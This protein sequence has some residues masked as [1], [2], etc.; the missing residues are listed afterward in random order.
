MS[1]A[2]RFPGGN[3]VKGP[4]QGAVAV[5]EEP[6]TEV[7]A[8]A[9]TSIF[10]AR[11][12]IFDAKEAVVAYE[13]LY[14][15][16]LNNSFD[17]TDGTSATLNVIRNAFLVLG[18]L[19]I[20]GKRA[21]INF[22]K[23]LLERKTGLSL[24]PA[25]TVI[26]ILEDVD[27]DSGIVEACRELKEAGYAL[28][29]DD[30]VLSAG[31]RGGLL[32]LAD[33]IKA[34]FRQM[35]PTERKNVVRMYGSSCQFLAEKV[36]TREEFDEAQAA[37]YIYFQG[38]FFGKPVI[39]SAN[40]IPG[41]KINYVRMLAEI[42]RKELDFPS[43][44]HI[45][46]QDP[47]LSYTLLNYMNSA[48][49]AFRVSVS[50]IRQALTLLG[51]KEITKWAS[52]VIMTFI[53]ADKPSEVSLCSLIRARF[54]EALAPVLG[55]HEKAAELFMMGILSMIDVLLGR[56]MSEILEKMNVSTDVKTALLGGTNLHSDVLNLIISYE[57]G[58]WQD[59]FGWVDKLSLD[60]SRFPDLYQASVEW[61]EQ[62][63]G[64]SSPP[65]G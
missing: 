10:V 33:I 4:E 8:D 6:T 31:D 63:F 36:E 17:S 15:S 59:F 9:K 57:R 21:F 32:K 19:L 25:T 65:H 48:F 61:A 37:G 14:R 51:E 35:D 38:Y 18:P 56:P 2:G 29:L 53:G 39:V 26:E 20:G 64:V 34:D 58:E 23:T 16:S 1:A 43:L 11:Q 42:N 50:S 24:N 46:K 45:I 5:A 7:F 28:A 27:V 55:I 44:E 52:L 3:R 40:S 62:V 60:Q 47:Y 12:P 22:N 49:F 30:F 54:C 13:L 41:N